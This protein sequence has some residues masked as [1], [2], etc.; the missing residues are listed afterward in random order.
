MPEERKQLTQEKGGNIM[1]RGRSQEVY[2]EGH[3][4]RTK[5]HKIVVFYTSS[6]RCWN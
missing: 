4:R 6:R 3:L 1:D 2:V 5:S